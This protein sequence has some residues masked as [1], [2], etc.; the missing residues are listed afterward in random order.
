MTGLSGNFRRGLR[1]FFLFLGVAA[2][3]L[4]FQACYGMP[5]DEYEGDEDGYRT[6]GEPLDVSNDN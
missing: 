2:V 4:V 3:S 5:I 1:R 6:E